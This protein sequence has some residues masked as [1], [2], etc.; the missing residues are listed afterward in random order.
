MDQ[1]LLEPPG[2]RFGNG[3]VLDE[4]GTDADHR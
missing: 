1:H 4:L 3:S 2:H